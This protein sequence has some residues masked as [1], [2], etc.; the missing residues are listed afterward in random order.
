MQL[1]NNAVLLDDTNSSYA[2]HGSCS[3]YNLALL[4]VLPDHTRHYACEDQFCT[5]W[6]MLL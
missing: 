6:Q 3:V 4:A 5:A 2:K 1:C